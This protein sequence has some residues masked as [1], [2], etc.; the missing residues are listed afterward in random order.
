MPRVPTG[1]TQKGWVGFYPNHTTSLL[2]MEENTARNEAQTVPYRGETPA[3]HD[4]SPPSSW[5]KAALPSTA[6][7]GSLADI[8]ML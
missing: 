4:P 1:P 3:F 8:K 2:L 7:K 5:S 6:W